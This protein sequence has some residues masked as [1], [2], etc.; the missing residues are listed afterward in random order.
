MSNLLLVLLFSSII[1]NQDQILNDTTLLKK[2]KQQT[3]IGFMA[4]YHY[5]FYPKGDVNQINPQVE[6]NSMNSN[7][8]ADI[9]SS[10]KNPNNIGYV[11]GDAKLLQVGTHL[12]THFKVKRQLFNM[13]YG[14]NFSFE[15]STALSS[16]EIRKAIYQIHKDYLYS[17]GD[18]SSLS[19]WNM[20]TT[21]IQKKRYEIGL[22]IPI[23]L[24]YQF[25]KRI[26]IETGVYYN[27]WARVKYR[28]Y[29]E[30]GNYTQ[31][32]NKISTSRYFNYYVGIN[33]QLFKN[34]VMQGG[35]NR[36]RMLFS[37]IRFYISN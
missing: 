3:K 31:N 28:Y 34:V 37:S 13:L 35:I 21:T 29:D 17:I 14:L 8:T 36:G 4:N 12:N 10:I 5:S 33:F 7:I 24:N 30:N 18:T 27:L 2:C 23:G 20:D 11:F 9:S 32:S 25:H 6:Y 15:E 16:V 26:G 22:T 19:S 1:S